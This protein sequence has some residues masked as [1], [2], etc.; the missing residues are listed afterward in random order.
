MVVVT[1]EVVVVGMEVVVVTPSDVRTVDVSLGVKSPPS[2]PLHPAEA[3][4]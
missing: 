3:R 2:E 1:M 4:A